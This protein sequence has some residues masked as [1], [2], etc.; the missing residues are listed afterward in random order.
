MQFARF[1]MDKFPTQQSQKEFSRE[2]NRK[3]TEVWE[4]II[5]NKAWRN[6]A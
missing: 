3:M 2:H 1:L 5:A 6:H 4:K